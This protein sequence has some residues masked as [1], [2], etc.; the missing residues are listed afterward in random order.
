MTPR[1]FTHLKAGGAFPQPTNDG[2]MASFAEARAAVKA[3]IAEIESRVTALGIPMALEVMRNGGLPWTLDFDSPITA[4]A[5]SALEVLTDERLD[6]VVKLH[7]LTLDEAAALCR[8]C[9]DLDRVDEVKKML[10]AGAARQSA[11]QEDVSERSHSGYDSECFAYPLH[12]ACAVGNIEVVKIL[13]AHNA[14]V[15]HHGHYE[16]ETA[17][18]VC[19]SDPYQHVRD[20][21]VSPETCRQ[22]MQLLV[23]HGADVNRECDSGGPLSLLQGG[24]TLRIELV[25]LLLDHGGNPN[26]VNDIGH[27]LLMQASIHN[28]FEIVRVLLERGADQHIRDPHEQST[29]LIL[30]AGDQHDGCYD[31]V[32]VLCAYGAD[33]GQWTGR[34]PPPCQQRVLCMAPKSR[35]GTP[36]VPRVHK[37]SRG[38]KWSK[39]GRR[40]RSPPPLVFRSRPRPRSGSASLTR[41]A[42]R[43]QSSCL[44][45]QRHCR[46]LVIS[47]GAK[48]TAA[49]SLGNI[50][51][52]QTQQ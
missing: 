33:I 6:A 8:L 14:D 38:C 27:T 18:T 49:P 17:L 10:Q 4:A 13:L 46:S 34:E 37:P 44:G 40:F 25:E 51:R 50:P 32:K 15:E 39:A 45:Q 20:G 11:R 31:V 19:A 1:A 47:C 35:L 36:S 41:P 26:G 52:G 29:A 21:K 42:S 12:G 28:E 30:A 24:A 22:T 5:K 48:N 2:R 9:T 16:R 43:S 23:D 7:E 3:E